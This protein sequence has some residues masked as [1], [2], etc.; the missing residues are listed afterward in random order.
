MFS[1]KSFFSGEEGCG[2][3]EESAVR[4]L[5]SAASPLLCRHAV[6]D[7]EN[8]LSGHLFELFHEDLPA[9]TT[10]PSSRSTLDRLLL[11]I[12]AGSPAAWN[13]Q[14]AF[15]YLSS[16]GLD[17]LL[18]ETLP[19]A[20]VVLLIR[21]SL[22][23]DDPESLVR[24]FEQLQQRGFGIGLF[25][26]PWHPGFAHLLPFATHGV[27]DAG[28]AEGS[29]IHDF[30]S[31]FSA[32]PGNAPRRFL[33][34]NID[35]LDEQRLCLHSGID[36][37]HGRFAASAPL[38]PHDNRSDPHKVQLLNLLQLVEAG[39][40]TNEV[41]RAIKEAPVLAFRILRYLNSPA[42]GLTRRIESINQA[43][44]ILG[45][46]RLTRWL[47]ILLFSTQGAGLAD[48]LLIESALTRGRLMEEL[49]A[50]MTPKLAGDPLFL[51]GIFSCLDRLL[52]RPLAEI[53]AEM[54]LSDDIRDALLTGKGPFA[55]LLAV[56]K[57]CENF[58][59]A[60]LEAAA[61]ASGLDCQSVNHAL[62]GATAWAGMVTGHWE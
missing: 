52:Q 20:N 28:A 17:S 36:F 14:T 18:T 1:I 4:P 43:L 23:D 5:P 10:D 22:R 50:L 57:A 32:A 56:A 60:Q 13:T 8:K 37:F 42:V 35:S 53:V 11:G 34:I 25:Y 7:R 12:L 31:L 38:R 46:Q 47:A 40:E 21:L 58:D 9:G 16:G 2:K 27:I 19:H 30:R 45:R 26:Q 29:D 55:P 48:W 41:A 51:T 61:H 39:A 3:A 33:A 24:R 6:F 54:P 44:I 49:G 59:P 62:L 15:I